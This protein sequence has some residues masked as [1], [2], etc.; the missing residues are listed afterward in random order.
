MLG[1]VNVHG[2]GWP[3]VNGEIRLTVAIEIESS[4]HYSTFDRLLEYCG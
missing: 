3:T 2:L 1:R 4:E